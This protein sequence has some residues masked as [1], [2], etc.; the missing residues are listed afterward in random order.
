VSVIAVPADV[1]DL[2]A[3]L[4]GKPAQGKAVAYLCRG[5]TCDA[6]LHDLAAVQAALQ[7]AAAN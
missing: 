5:N 1:A 3:A 4:A 2:P 6:P 7:Y